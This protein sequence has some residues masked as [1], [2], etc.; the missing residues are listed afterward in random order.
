MLDLF[1]NWSIAILIL[2]I[3]IELAYFFTW[4]IFFGCVVMLYGWILINYIIIRRTVLKKHPA[5][6]LISLGLGLFYYYFPLFGTLIYQRP[7][8]FKFMLPLSVFLHQAIFVTVY[9]LA[10][11]IYKKSAIRPIG[12]RKIYLKLNM[13]TP[14]SNSMLW[15]MGFIGVMIFLYTKINVGV[16]QL[17]A[18]E[19][20]PL[21]R[22]L[23]PMRYFV[24]APLLILFPNLIKPFGSHFDKNKNHVSIYL[25]LAGLTIMSFLGNSR[26]FMVSSILTL[27]LLSMYD[28]LLCNKPVKKIVNPKN[29]VMG[30]ALVL[31]T[32]GPLAKMAEAML[33][34]RG[35]RT[36]LSAV[37]L[38]QATL[39][40]Y[41]SSE[42]DHQLKIKENINQVYISWDEE[43]TGNIFFDR[44][45]N[46][47][48]A[49]MTLYYM[50]KAKLE[51]SFAWEVLG[52]QWIAQVP[53]PIL[54]LSG[55]RLDK[56]SDNSTYSSTSLAKKN[57][58]EG[59][60]G[61]KAVAAHT[62]TGLW[63]FGIWYPFFFIGIYFFLFF[64]LDSLT[65]PT[66]SGPIF[67]ML[68]LLNIYYF[69]TLMN[70][71]NGVFSDILFMGR[72]FIEMIFLYVFVFFI[73]RK[74]SGFFSEI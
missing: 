16:H 7:L 43:Y 5:I 70:Y 12:L 2:L 65:I 48:I 32:M 50:R 59:G 51:R 18:K 8:T 39:K 10:F 19:V 41:N 71:K 69:M 11:I 14:P 37:E 9:V 55:T 72:S 27:A 66:Y 30:L 34:V 73:S 28:Y 1:K 36:N 64:L 56:Y 68:F 29:I 52:D 24:Y 31:I 23:L 15:I 60:D 58:F 3:W 53:Q 4:E 63:L 57:L 38:F 35:E 17:E 46:L 13:F 62:G 26:D 49:D 33:M 25:Y 22:F 44:M 54:N 61:G 20:S 42:L 74:I 47:R 45:C 6:F 40:A 67:S 21:I